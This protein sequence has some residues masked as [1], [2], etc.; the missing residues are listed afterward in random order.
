LAALDEKL[1]EIYFE[2]A[3]CF[4]AQQ[5]KKQSLELYDKYLEL[6]GTRTDLTSFEQTHSSVAHE[7]V[8]Q[9]QKELNASDSAGTQVGSAAAAKEIAPANDHATATESTVGTERSTP[10]KSDSD[11]M[12]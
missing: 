12:K 7:K 2:K 6:L 8:T 5:D 3:M 11:Q 4:E 10:T 9:L 1:P